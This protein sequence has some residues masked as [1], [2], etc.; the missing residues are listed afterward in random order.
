M[1]LDKTDRTKLPY[2]KN[3]EGYFLDRD[4]NILAREM[5]GVLVFPGGG[6]DDGEDA[7]KAVI[8]ETFEETRAIL[9]NLRKIGEL[10]F[11]WGQTWAKTEKQ[12]IRY[13]QYKGE[14]MHFFAGEIT[15]FGDSEPGKR[16]E[17]S[18]DGKNIIPISEA[19]RIIELGM[20]F[21]DEIKEYREMQ[22]K[23]LRKIQNGEI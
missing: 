19:I 4:R 18:W 22:L 8:R 20:P 5:N 13:T 7:E 21:D 16:E 10:K 15:G 14:D 23:F 3:C 9:E 6:V 11:I 17:D 2:R 1:R 12:K